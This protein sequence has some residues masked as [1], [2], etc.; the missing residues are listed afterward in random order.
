MLSFFRYCFSGQEYYV[1]EADSRE[2]SLWDH[3]EIIEEE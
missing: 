3:E 2:H 1:T